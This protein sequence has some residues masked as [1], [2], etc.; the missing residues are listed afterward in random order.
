MPPD[1]LDLSTG[2]NP[3]GPCKAAREAACAALCSPYPDARA[4]AARSSVAERFRLQP[5]QVLLGHGAT[6]L[7]F[8][9]ARALAASPC[10]W[11]SIE[12]GDAE[13]AT[14]ARRAGARITRWRS[15]ERTGHRVDLEQVAELMRLER[16]SVVSLCAPGSP[17]GASVPFASLCELARKFPDTRFVVEQ[18]WLSL[19]DD[20]AD[21]ELAPAAN[22]I[23]IRSLS[24]DCALPG[25][26]AGYA[27]ASPAL[28]G[29]IDAARPPYTAG[30]A[31]QAL[32]QWA[33]QEPGF[34]AESR[35]R[36]QA[37][38]AR[39]AQV[40]DT[41]GLVYTPSVAP[42]LL[43]RVARAQEVALE[44]LEHH[45]IAV[46]DT[47]PFGLPDHLRISAVSAD[48]APRLRAALA[49]VTARRG[50]VAGREP[51]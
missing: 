35:V 11:L 4:A 36:L 15:V 46:C 23:C 47:T 49:E 2:Q 10:V 18:S 9:C 40:L 50:L 48:A 34:V 28:I 12:P 8:S 43:V 20:F 13:F 44:L 45:Q 27:I 19:S 6:E 33:M 39:L 51:A 41:L 22:V 21:L 30:A 26:R 16:P 32:V 42:F 17:T 14:A 7:A 5:E 37:D 3:Y 1:L 25:A 29:H 31:A 24:L 38:K